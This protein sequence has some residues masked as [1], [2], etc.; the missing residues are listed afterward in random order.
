MKLPA[1]GNRKFIVAL[2]ALV[3]SFVLALVGVLAGEHWVTTI[4]LI[5][6]LFGAANVGEHV[7]KGGE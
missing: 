5:V 6:G 1:K 4:G 7:A 2:I 3:M